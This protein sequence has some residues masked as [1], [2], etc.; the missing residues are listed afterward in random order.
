[1]K[2]IRQHFE[3]EK[4]I[5]VIEGFDYLKDSSGTSKVVKSHEILFREQGFDYVCIY[6][7]LWAY[8]VGKTLTGIYGVS[9]NGKLEGFI[10]LNNLKFCLAECERNG[11]KLAGILIHHIIYNRLD[12]LGN[13]LQAFPLTKKVFYLHDYWTCCLSINM[14]REK[15]RNSWCHSD[16]KE[17]CRGC[18]WHN[19]NERHRLAIREFFE[20]IGDCCF[21]APSESVARGWLQWN[22]S[23]FTN[24]HVIGHLKP[25]SYSRRETGALEEPIRVAF[26]GAAAVNKG[27]NEFVSIAKQCG[28]HVRLYHMG[29]TNLRLPSVQNVDVQIHKQGL[30]AMI[31]ALKEN[32]IDISLLLS[33]WLETYSYTL[34]E[35]LQAKSLVCC[36]EDSGNVADVVHETGLGWCFKDK[37]Q[38]QDF[39]NSK[40]LVSLVRSKQREAIFPQAMVTNDEIISYFVGEP[41]SVGDAVLSVRY[42]PAEDV[43]S[44]LTSVGIESFNFLKVIVKYLIRKI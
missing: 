36:L 12:I 2:S 23:S 38:I 44:V 32:R 35:S 20:K 43:K 25:R 39:L 22:P 5:L 40:D 14:M 41:A 27:W 18:V 19:A 26:V 8:H 15:T 24:V 3:H 1:M 9:V 34:F 13:F 37:E 31:R 29:H 6:P 33:G 42:S 4:F 21:V 16:L 10:G 30:D 17:G 28:K 11:H 7:L